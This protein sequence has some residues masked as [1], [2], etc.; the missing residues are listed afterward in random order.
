[1]PLDDCGRVVDRSSRELKPHGTPGFPC[2]GYDS[3][4]TGPEDAVPWHWHVEIEVIRVVRGQLRVQVPGRMV[5]LE[6]GEGVFLSANLLHRVEAA[7]ECHIHALV[8]HPRLVTGGEDTVFYRKYLGPLLGLAA[9]QEVALNQEE[10]AWVESA[11]DQM[12]GEG[13]GWEFDVREELSKLCL[14]LGK[15][16]LTGA[17][18]T[19]SRDAARLQEMLEYIHMNYGE[20]LTLAQVARSVNISTR[21]CLRCFER[22]AGMPPMQYLS[23]YRVARAAELLR[24]SD[25]AIAQIGADC[26]FDS[27]SRFAQVFKRHYQVTPR[28]YRK[29]VSRR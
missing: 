24:Q 22:M 28:A 4:Y 16:L 9:V 21:E 23:S 6:A 8:F 11:F 25:A 19:P 14:S 18:S 20:K 3:C 12:A 10:A 29:A 1:M 27:P 2:A 15:R 26:G 7:R 17:E 5:C 13:E